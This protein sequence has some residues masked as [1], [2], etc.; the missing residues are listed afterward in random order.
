MSLKLQQMLRSLLNMNMNLE[1]ETK[2][3]ITKIWR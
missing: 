3:Y 1:S 2:K